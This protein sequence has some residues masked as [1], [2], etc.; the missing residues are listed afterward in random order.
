MLMLYLVEVYTTMR[1]KDLEGCKQ[2]SAKNIVRTLVLAI[3]SPA[4]GAQ[5][6]AW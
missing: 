5:T 2:H 3:S 4:T 1:T 6:L